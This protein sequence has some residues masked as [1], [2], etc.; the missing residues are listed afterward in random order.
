M[1]DIVIPA[2]EVYTLLVQVDR[3]LTVVMGKV[4]S[5]IE[6]SSDHET[7]I[8]SLESEVSLDTSLAE[9]TK[10]VAELAQQMGTMQKIVWGIPASM[11]VA[12]AAVAV[13]VLRSV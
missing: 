2:G 1:S 12:L 7:R 8:R 13:A 11:L 6:S 4:D 9:V 5:L 10:D 3:N